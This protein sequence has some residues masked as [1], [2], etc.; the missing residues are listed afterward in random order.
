MQ[1]PAMPSNY[2]LSAVV[3]HEGTLGRGHYYTFARP[4]PD[5]FPR[6]W[7]ELNDRVVRERNIDEVLR[8]SIGSEGE[9]N[10]QSYSR[11]A[12]MLLYE[13]TDNVDSVGSPAAAT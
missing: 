9:D 12:Y 8:V 7:L 13:R 3:V 10:R 2:R 1:Q 11:N 4:E 5:S 6:R